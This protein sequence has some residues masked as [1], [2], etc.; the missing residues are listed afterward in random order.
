MEDGPFERRERRDQAAVK[1]AGHCAAIARQPDVSANDFE[2]A[3][4]VLSDGSGVQIAYAIQPSQQS[5][6]H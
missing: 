2:I 6:Q 5:R 4:T 1:S 3:V